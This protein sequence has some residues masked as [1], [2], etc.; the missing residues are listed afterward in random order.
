[1]RALHPKPMESSHAAPCPL[2]FTLA[3]L[4]S[5]TR[6]LL[7]PPGPAPIHSWTA[8]NTPPTHTHTSL[9][10]SGLGDLPPSKYWVGSSASHTLALH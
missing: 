7:H 3:P 8:S 4:A 10:L 2:P 9:L 1:M 5:W 6:V